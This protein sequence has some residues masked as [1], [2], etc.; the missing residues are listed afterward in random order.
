MNH[1]VPT[2]PWVL[3]LSIDLLIPLSEDMDNFVTLYM[4]S[5]QFQT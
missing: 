3:L 1:M 5:L 4:D 2:S